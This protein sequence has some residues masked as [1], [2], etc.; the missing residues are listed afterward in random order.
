[1]QE[2]SDLSFIPKRA[3][4]R[5]R[6]SIYA[7][8]VLHLLYLI[9][10]YVQKTSG[11][12][13]RRSIRE[14]LTPETVIKA[15]RAEGRSSGRGRYDPSIEQKYLQLLEKLSYSRWFD[16]FLKALD[17]F[18]STEW[19]NT[20]RA[21]AGFDKLESSVVPL[22]GPHAWR[23]VIPAIKPAVY[24]TGVNVLVLEAEAPPLGNLGKAVLNMGSAGDR[25]LGVTARISMR[26]S[27]LEV[28]V[29]AQRKGSTLRLAERVLFYPA[30][31]RLRRTPYRQLVKAS[32]SA[33]EELKLM[34]ASRFM[35]E[36]MVE[37]LFAGEVRLNLLY[38]TPVLS[39]GG[40][41]CIVGAAFGE[42]VAPL[43]GTQNRAV[44]GAVNV[45]VFCSDLSPLPTPAGLP[46]GSYLFV[47]AAPISIPYYT[48]L[49][50]AWSTDFIGR[51]H[52]KRYKSIFSRMDSFYPD[53]PL[54]KDVFDF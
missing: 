17:V 39:F 13:G 21:I 22:I 14:T 5:I 4:K 8:R 6:R 49:L 31:L 35:D 2:A 38:T 54:L 23:Y 16:G 50:G 24:I 20:C 32:I 19:I 45:P 52:L 25:Y 27:D 9:F 40:M 12:Y 41:L 36:K 15:I 48:V 51:E 37:K 47:F 53:L 26:R 33:N 10:K 46:Q 11:S 30:A 28:V 42:L 18:W 3:R 44:I 29:Q 34:I 1:L 43:R 7:G